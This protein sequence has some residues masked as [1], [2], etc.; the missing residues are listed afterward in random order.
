M[1]EAKQILEASKALAKASSNDAS[2]SHIVS[3]L[4]EVKTGVVPSEDLLR[5]TKIGV[6]VNKFKQSRNPEINRLASEIVKK[7]KDDIQKQKGSPTI[8]HKA[9]P[10]TNG[11]AT[12]PVSRASPAPTATADSIKS[13]VPPEKRDYKTD[14]VDTKRTHQ[15]VRDSSIGLFYNGL[16]F[17]STESPDEIIECAIACEKAA[18]DT[19]GPETNKAYS[20][21]I[22]SLY[23]NLKNKS[24][25]KLRANV[26]SSKI[27]A[28]R[29]VQM[30][31]DE[32]KSAERREEDQKLKDENLKDSYVPKEEKS[33]SGS[34]QCGKC[35]QKKVSYSQAQTRSA[36]EPMTTFCEC[37]NCGRRWKVRRCSL[38]GS[39][40]NYI[41][42]CVSS[43][44]EKVY[45]SALGFDGRI[46]QFE[47]L[48]W[49]FELG[50][51]Y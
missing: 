9:S 14:K 4:N 39:V 28:Q 13:T 43:S 45:I 19:F 8:G 34:L 41:L 21:K 17:M 46:L 16:A 12:P 27:P 42:I 33:I 26:L 37:M 2:P 50:Q 3:L 10:V 32:L 1:M 18:F 7:W 31:A 24:N 30:T 51:R 38:R 23:Q 36:D 47:C 49:G 35:G 22:R 29:F 6:T 40:N 44:P 20:A 48:V 15:T 25:S 11:K 5:S